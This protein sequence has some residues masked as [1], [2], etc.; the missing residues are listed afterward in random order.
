MKANEIQ[1]GDWLYYKGQFNAFPFKVESITKKKVGYHAESNE[2]RIYYLRLSECK[3][4]LLSPE[5]LEKNGFNKN[6]TGQWVIE[7]KHSIGCCG[8]TCSNTNPLEYAVWWDEF[9]LGCVSYLEKEGNIT[10]GG[11]TYVHQ[12]QQILRLFDLDKFIKIEL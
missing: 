7:K 9:G 5:I 2:H 12:L 1:I 6:K 3:P 4:I 11:T 10:L 8:Q